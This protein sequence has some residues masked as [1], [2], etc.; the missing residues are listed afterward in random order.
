[1]K[2][3]MNPEAEGVFFIADSPPLNTREL[4]ESIA[5][6]MGKK[7]YIIR[8]PVFLARLTELVSWYFGNFGIHAALFTKVGEFG[9]NY[10]ADGSKADTLL[11]LPKCSP[12]QGFQDMTRSY[13]MKSDP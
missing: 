4:Y 8:L 1:M 13:F 11:A 5:N 10:V 12:A 2:A 3:A 9:R 6:A 7:I